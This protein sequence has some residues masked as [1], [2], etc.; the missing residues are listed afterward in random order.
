M[1]LSYSVRIYSGSIFLS[2][3]RP[4]PERFR[5][6]VLPFDFPQLSHFARRPEIVAAPPDTVPF[7]G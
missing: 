4:V 3:G 6:Q 5:G 1:P 2:I 7:D